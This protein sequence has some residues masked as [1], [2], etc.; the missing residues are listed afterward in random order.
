MRED[1]KDWLLCGQEIYLLHKLLPC[2][3]SYSFLLECT[4]QQ[5]WMKTPNKYVSA[6]HCSQSFLKY[7]L[8]VDDVPF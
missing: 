2:Y 6:R 3:K 4:F 7:H 5:L 8:S 1:S